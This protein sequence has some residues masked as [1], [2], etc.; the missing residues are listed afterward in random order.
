MN[1]DKKFMTLALKEATKAFLEM[2]WK[3]NLDIVDACRDSWN[4]Q[5]NNPQGYDN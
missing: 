3:A 5:K 2:G 1:I 4:W